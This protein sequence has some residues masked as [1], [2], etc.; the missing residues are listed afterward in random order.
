M[1]PL[2]KKNFT[3]INLNCF[4][5]AIVNS[6][7]ETQH[8][9]LN[10]RIIPAYILFTLI[11]SPLLYVYVLSGEQTYL[12]RFSCISCALAPTETLNFLLSSCRRHYF[13]KHLAR[14]HEMTSWK[15]R[16][17]T[18]ILSTY[19][20]REKGIPLAIQVL[21]GWRVK[22]GGTNPRPRSVNQSAVQ[23]SSLL[24]TQAFWLK[25]L[26]ELSASSVGERTLGKVSGSC[27]GSGG[28]AGCQ[29]SLFGKQSRV[30]ISHFPSDNR[31]IQKQRRFFQ[32]LGCEKTPCKH[33]S[34]HGW[35]AAPAG[36][37]LS[38]GQIKG[39][40]L[41]SMVDHEGKRHRACG[42]LHNSK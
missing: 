42:S 14:C 29:Q 11:F 21:G 27:K 8:V 5:C 31:E 24:S 23:Y 26:P 7:V 37:H 17:F 34:K 10:S 35:E 16:G 36:G 38:L 32:Q 9:A 20:V 6:E 2:P 41:E 13:K 15:W 3:F 4:G 12:Y 30:Q 18:V 1:C 40:D 19:T 39:Q 28:I 25:K 33:D 22:A